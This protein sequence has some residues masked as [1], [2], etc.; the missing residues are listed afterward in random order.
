MTKEEILQYNKR[1]AEFLGYKNLTPDDKDFNIYENEKGMI[2]GNKIYTLLETMSMTFHSD[3]NWIMEVLKQIT[4]YGYNWEL[5]D[6]NGTVTEE[7]FMKCSIFNL[8]LSKPY[9]KFT[10]ES[11]DEKEAV[12]QAINQFLICRRSLV[13]QRRVLR[14]PSYDTAA[15]EFLE[16]CNAN[17]DNPVREAYN[18]DKFK[19]K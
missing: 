19:N 4:K 10:A 3:W 18:L 12:V 7:K 14:V 16:K 5:I 1:C 15:I 9:N 8:E 11:S 6:F 13:F 17:L 2:I